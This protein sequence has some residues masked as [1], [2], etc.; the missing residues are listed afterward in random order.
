MN[1][2]L[3]DKMTVIPLMEMDMDEPSGNI[4]E[5]GLPQILPL[6]VLRNAVVFP[7]TLIPITVGRDKS[8]KLV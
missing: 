7:G 8:I 6:L 3:S 1:L 2:I 5:D 4:R